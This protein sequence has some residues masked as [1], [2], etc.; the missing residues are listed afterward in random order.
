MKTALLFLL[1]S[2]YLF[3]ANQCIKCHEGL[4]HIRHG[5]SGMMQAILEVAKNAGHEGNDCIV[6]HGGTPTQKSKQY[7]HKGT[8]KYFKENEGP[9]EFYPAPGSTWINQNTCGMCHQEQVSAQMNSLMMT[10][11]GKIQGALWS[12]GGKNGYNHDIGNY[13]T[14]NPDDPHKRLGTDKYKAYMSKLALMEPQ[15]FPSEMKELP[16]APTA[17]EVEKDPSLAVYTYLRQECLRCHTGSKGRQKRGDFRG[18]GCASCHIPYSNEGYYEG[19]DKSINK[20]EK[21]HLLVHAIQSSRDA[22]VKVH[23]VEYSGIPVETCST[24]H[25]RGKRIGVSYQGLMEKAYNSPYDDEG[26]GQ[27]KLH[28]KRY[29]HMQSD[30]HFQKGMLCQDCHTSNDMHGDG[31]LGGANAAAVEVEC[32]DCHGTTKMYPWELPLGFS[33]EFNTTQATGVA[34]GVTKTMAEYLKKG[35]Y[36]EPRDGYLITARGNPLTHAVKD[37]TDIIMHLASGKDIKLT[38]LKKLKETDKLSPKGLLAMDSISSHTEEMECYACHAAWAPQCYGC[39]VKIDYSKGKQN[40]DYLKASH[41]HDIHGK[42]GGMKDM[43]KY[44]VD[45]AVTETRSFMR[46]EDPPLAQNGEGRIS[47]TVPGCQTTITVIGK[48]GK[49][50]LKNHI[51]KV[52]NVEGA[53]EEGQNAIDMAPIQPHTISKEGRSCESC[54]T[55]PKAMGMGIGGSKSTMDPSLTTITDI[56]TVDGKILPTIVDE[57]MPAIANLKYDYSKFLDENGTQLQTVGHHWTLSGPLSKAQ[58]DKLDRSGVCFSCHQDIPKGNLGVSALTHIADMTEVNIDNKMHK[59]IVNKSLN[60][61]AWFQVIIGILVSILVAYGIYLQFFK[62]KRTNPRN[63][64]W[65]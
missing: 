53:G 16:R 28:T 27:P 24:C 21:G 25:N 62:K 3:G 46:F 58:R 57:Q 23:D 1:L 41:D 4:E 12:F 63:E 55:M 60:I 15:A 64:G 30:V 65:K 19:G 13:K 56:M 32:Q 29:M 17:E 36:N 39:H 51:Y 9:K 37:G 59:N 54:H 11:Q 8:V 49:A 38:P 18:I 26:S 2:T 14:K 22:K 43:R 52:K 35:S 47:P 31:F 10:E 48:D 5:S 6:C 50:L 44:L 7:A 20:K 45:G 40:P 34:R 42:T 61:A 33:D